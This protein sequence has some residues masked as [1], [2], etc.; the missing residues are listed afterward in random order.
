MTATWR[1]FSNTI[2]GNK[3]YIAGRIKNPDQP[4]HSGNVEYNGE[5]TIDRD[6][7][8]IRANELNQSA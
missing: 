1:V 4:L 6:T 3:M 5:Y 7:A 8:E 2:N